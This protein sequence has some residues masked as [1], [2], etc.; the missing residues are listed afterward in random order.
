[1]TEPHAFDAEAAAYD[2]A[3]TASQIGRRA[4]ARYWARLDAHLQPGMRVLELGGGTGE[5]AC[6]LAE[7]GLHVT[8]TDASPG[9][10]AMARAKAEARGLADRVHTA[11]LDMNRLALDEDP[12]ALAGA[13]LFEAA[14]SNFGALNCV[15]DLP[16]LARALSP[17]LRPGAPVLLTVMGPHC[18][19]EWVWYLAQGQPRKAFRRWKRGGTPWRGMTIHY[20]ATRTLADAFAPHFALREVRVVNALLPPSYAEARFQRWPRL[21]ATLDHLDTRWQST[22]LLS[23]LADHYLA[24]FE[25]R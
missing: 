2:D 7:R 6:H 10:L 16:G 18:P 3:F 9:M 15:A 13:P 19:W 23:T 5:D 12:D 24:I 17:H 22:R 25:R 14:C 11:V 20:P 1:M 21:L 4:R 8:C